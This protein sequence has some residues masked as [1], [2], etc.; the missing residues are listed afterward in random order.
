[1]DRPQQI[2]TLAHAYAAAEGLNLTTVSKRVFGSSSR[3]AKLMDDGDVFSRTGDAA[4]DWFS[5]NWPPTAAW[6]ADVLRQQLG[7]DG[8][9]FPI[10]MAPAVAATEP[11]AHASSSLSEKTLG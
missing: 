7:A 4:I 3:L 5:R 6:P 1:M 9:L 8:C 11:V 2:I 10:D